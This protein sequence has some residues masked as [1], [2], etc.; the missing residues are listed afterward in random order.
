MA[1]VHSELIPFIET[2]SE[3]EKFSKHV[4]DYK[5]IA[6][7]MTVSDFSSNYFNSHYGELSVDEEILLDQISEFVDKLELLILH[8]SYNSGKNDSV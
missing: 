6:P 3:L 5:Q 7:D 2:H 8:K 4:M 1:S